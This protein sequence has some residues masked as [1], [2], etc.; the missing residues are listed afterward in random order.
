MQGAEPVFIVAKK[1]DDNFVS[2][3]FNTETNDYSIAEEIG[4]GLREAKI[5]TRV[6]SLDEMC[7]EEES[8]ALKNARILIVVS[9]RKEYI[10]AAYR[11]ICDFETASQNEMKRII[12]LY[13]AGFG[14]VGE[15][16]IPLTASSGV[17]VESF[18][19][20]TENNVAVFLD[21][22]RIYLER[23][24]ADKRQCVVSNILRNSRSATNIADEGSNTER[25]WLKEK[26]DIWL[27][28]KDKRHRVF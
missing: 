18:G 9:T 21:R 19:I 16:E 5:G 7:D 10:D 27:R 2:M 17:I 3:G 1:M 24:E 28:K 11:I 14:N 8:Q 4:S 26:M 15:R 13:I 25:V 22:I 12:Y 20:S 23:Y 6:K